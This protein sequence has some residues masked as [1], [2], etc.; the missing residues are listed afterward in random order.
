MS[1]LYDNEKSKEVSLDIAGKVF[2]LK[3][4]D[5]LGVFVL[6]LLLSFVYFFW[7]GMALSLIDY[8]FGRHLVEAIS[9]SFPY[10]VGYIIIVIFGAF[11]LTILIKLYEKYR[12]E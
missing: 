11:V 5:A 9:K 1:T 12:K 4:F 10:F 6:C 8:L 7:G 3:P 2:K